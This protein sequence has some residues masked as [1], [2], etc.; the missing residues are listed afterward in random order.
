MAIFKPRAIALLLTSGCTFT[1]GRES[2]SDTGATGGLD[3]PELEPPTDVTLIDQGT[4]I[5]VAITGGNSSSWNFGIVFDSQEIFEE[6]CIGTDPFCHTLTPSGGLVV[7]CS[8]ASDDC[9][10]I[11]ATFFQQD[12][13]S[14][15][16][17]PP[18]G[19]DCWTWGAP[20]THYD[21]ENC[22]EMPWSG[23]GL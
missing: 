20:P 8:P 12:S 5:N 16:L 22:T 14:F 6:G 18:S 15:Y 4:A 1:L 2:S 19:P 3:L 11:A 21:G 17:A 9:T 10:A 7:Y 13:I 23:V